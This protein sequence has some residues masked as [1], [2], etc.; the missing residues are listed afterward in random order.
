M[1]IQKLL[2]D[3]DDIQNRFKNLNETFVDDETPV[4]ID[5]VKKVLDILITLNR[6][7]D[8]E[9]QQRTAEEFKANFLKKLSDNKAKIEAIS[10]LNMH[11]EFSKICDKSKDIKSVILD[12]LR[13]DIDENMRKTISKWTIQWN[14]NEMRSLPDSYIHDVIHNV[15]FGTERFRYREQKPRFNHELDDYEPPSSPLCSDK[16][17]FFANVMLD[18][19]ELSENLKADVFQAYMLNIDPTLLHLPIKITRFKATSVSHSDL[20][21]QLYDHYSVFVLSPVIK[22]RRNV[23]LRD[24]GLSCSGDSYDWTP[25]MRRLI[26]DRFEIVAPHMTYFFATQIILTYE[27]EQS[28]KKRPQLTARSGNIYKT[29]ESSG[30]TLSPT[31]SSDGW[32]SVDS[33]IHV[34]VEEPSEPCIYLVISDKDAHQASNRYKSIN[35]TKVQVFGEAIS[36]I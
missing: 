5:D 20:L 31:W 14:R 33:E 35:L 16:E 9:L 13:G 11:S 10:S 8:Y 28:A 3:F 30:E 27:H 1:S 18:R 17:L 34:D 6:R 23:T 25:K 29:S 19:V 15:K 4:S 22:F 7:G 32:W 24:G 21:Q 12:V 26:F 2:D 36:L